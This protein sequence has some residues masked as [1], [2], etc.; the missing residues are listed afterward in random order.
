MY[1][2]RQF[3]QAL[4]AAFGAVAVPQSL[5]LTANMVQPVTFKFSEGYFYWTHL[6][7]CDYGPVLEFNPSL[8]V[9]NDKAFEI[10]IVAGKLSIKISKMCCLSFMV[11]EYGKRIGIGGFRVDKDSNAHQIFRMIESEHVPDSVQHG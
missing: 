11:A 6:Y 7:N 10:D 8:L 2:R 3:I 1:N 4:A 5:S 9:A